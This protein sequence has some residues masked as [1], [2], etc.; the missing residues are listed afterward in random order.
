MATSMQTLPQ[1]GE[2]IFIERWF[3]VGMAIV[4]IATSIAGF[5]PPS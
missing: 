1:I 2:N 3:F 5:G 4:M